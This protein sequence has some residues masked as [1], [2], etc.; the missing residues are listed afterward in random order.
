MTTRPR[1]LSPHLLIY[2]VT[3]TMVMSIVHRITGVALYAGTLLLVAWL[4]A[5]AIGGQPLDIVHVVFGSWFGQIVLFGYTWALFHHMLG[6][7]RH[8]VWDTANGLDHP[9]RE[10]IVRIHLASSILLTLLVWSVFVWF[11]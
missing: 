5:A 6:G 10:W 3:L 4:V 8:F 11:R 7:I 2:R 9:A 1:P